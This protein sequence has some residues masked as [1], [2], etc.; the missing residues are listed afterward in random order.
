MIR[1]GL[2]RSEFLSERADRTR[3]VISHHRGRAQSLHCVSSLG[4]GLLSL[5]DCALQPLMSFVRAMWEQVR[6][7]LKLQQDT[8]KTL[9]QSVVQV[10]RDASPLADPLFHT[11]VEYPRHLPQTQ[12]IEHTQQ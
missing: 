6:H 8:L 9:E 5:I 11:Q 2:I 3:Q 4:D 7:S 1:A 10:P 12:S